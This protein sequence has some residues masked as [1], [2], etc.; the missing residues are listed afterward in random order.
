MFLQTRNERVDLSSATR[1]DHF[2][3]IV[4]SERRTQREDVVKNRTERVDVGANIERAI[5]P[6]ACSGDMYCGVP[7]T[8]PAIVA[9]AAAGSFTVRTIERIGSFFSAGFMR[10]VF[11]STFA[12]PIHHEPTSPKPPIMMFSGF[13]SDGSR[14][15]CERTHRGR[16]PLENREQMRQ[17]IF[18]LR[19]RVACCEFSSIAR[20]V[21][22]RTN[23]I[24]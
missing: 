14:S 5:S 6:R 15:C 3:R 24:V 21:T 12:R 4:A 2:I 17:W 10:S 23:F 7:T 18:F 13:R 8:L 22:P 20:S 1:T 11:V 19:L 16:T 9:P